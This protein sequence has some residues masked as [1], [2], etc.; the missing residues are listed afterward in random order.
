M[1]AFF[2]S[3]A[4]RFMGFASLVLSLVFQMEWMIMEQQFHPTIFSYS[5][6]QSYIYPAFVLYFALQSWWL[7]DYA[8]SASSRKGS[9]ERGS[10]VLED[11]AMQKP[12]CQS[13]MPIL[14]LSNI[15]MVIWTILCT[16]QLY[17]LGLAVVTFSACV[18][19]CGVFGALQVIRQS[20]FYQERSGMTLT[21]AKVNAA[22]TIMYLWKT[23]G[24]MESSANPPS[25]QLLHS[26][27]IF[28]LLTLTSGPDPTFGL[29]LIYVL[30]AL[31][32]GPSK[33][34]AWRD[35]FFWT[36]AV[37]SALV[38]IDPII[39]LLHYSFTSEEYEEPTENTPFLTLDMKVRASPED[40][41]ALLPL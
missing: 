4:I 23:W 38:V 10:L 7:V 40:I 29:S 12:I 3:I 28:V 31:Y 32:N 34:L 2:K 37:L 19:L 39:C 26:A 5:I 35:T 30:A 6:N 25:L 9:E 22:Y 33:S 8:K 15:C 14:V 24:M 17:S 41:P 18:Q 27:G 11:T 1:S 21:L 13:Y 20:D 16:V 36:A